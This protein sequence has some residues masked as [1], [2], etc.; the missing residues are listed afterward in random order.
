MTALWDLK[1][2]TLTT[3]NEAGTLASV[4][5]YV[6]GKPERAA[7]IVVAMGKERAS[8]I[9][10]NFRSEELKTVIGAARRLE[11]IPQSQL[12][13]VVAE[14]EADFRT[15]TGLLD[16]SHAF[17]DIL[18]DV[19]AE[20]PDKMLGSKKV[21]KVPESTE[22]TVWTTLEEFDSERLSK[23]LNGQSPQLVAIILSQL[24]SALVA[25]LLGLIEPDLS[26]KVLLKLAQEISLPDDV[27]PYVEA[28]IKSGLGLEKMS[29]Y[30]KLDQRIAEIL[31]AVDSNVSDA[32]VETLR[33]N[34]DQY[35]IKNIEKGVFRFEAIEKMDKP[36]RSAVFDDVPSEIIATALAG[37]PPGL[38]EAVLEA[39]SPRT[40]RMIE[41]EMQGNENAKPEKIDGARKDICSIILKSASEGHIEL[42]GR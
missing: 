32:M 23:F 18:N 36:S 2:L 25:K 30:N 27:K 3:W 20:D 21:E 38:V 8:Q 39:V 33:S 6:L 11:T 15:G 42:P 19:L 24:S 34:V 1:S 10:K 9:L 31:N 28:H 17:E 35:R 14:F 37:A 12:E 16:S 13:E 41:G 29:T 7:A 26:Q 40:R 4:S 22:K 5:R